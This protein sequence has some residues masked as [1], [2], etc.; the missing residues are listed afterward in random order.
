LYSEC[1]RVGPIVVRDFGELAALGGQ[2]DEPAASKQTADDAAV[3]VQRLTVAGEVEEEKSSSARRTSER[4]SIR[5]L[6]CIQ[7]RRSMA[8]MTEH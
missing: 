4:P 6:P 8:E 1:T 3:G 2:A 5:I 7:K